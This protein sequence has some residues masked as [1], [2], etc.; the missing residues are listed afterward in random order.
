MIRVSLREKQEL[1]KRKG[2]QK[3]LQQILRTWTKGDPK[4]KEKTKLI[5]F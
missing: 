4:E 1:I 5:S 2:L 3:G